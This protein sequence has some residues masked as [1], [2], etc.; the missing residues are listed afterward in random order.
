MSTRLIQLPDG[1]VS[2]QSLDIALS[3]LSQVFGK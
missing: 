3:E 1:V 2:E